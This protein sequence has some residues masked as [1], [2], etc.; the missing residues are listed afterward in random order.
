[1][2]KNSVVKKFE[3]LASKYGF[4]QNNLLDMYDID[5]ETN[6][7]E[8]TLF[9]IDDVHLERRTKRDFETE[10]GDL[11][12][13]G[14]VVVKCAY[15]MRWCLACFD[16][17]EAVLAG[18]HAIHDE[19]LRKSCL[20]YEAYWHFNSDFLLRSVMNEM[21]ETCILDTQ[22]FRRAH[23]FRHPDLDNASYQQIFKV[24]SEIVMLHFQYNGRLL[25]TN[26]A[27]LKISLLATKT[28]SHGWQLPCQG[29]SLKLVNQKEV[30]VIQGSTFSIVLCYDQASLLLGETAQ[31]TDGEITVIHQ[32]QVIYSGEHSFAIDLDDNNAYTAMVDRWYSGGSRWVSEVL[33][34][35]TTQRSIV[36][37]AE[38]IETLVFEACSNLLDIGMNNDLGNKLKIHERLY[39]RELSWHNFNAYLF[40]HL[41][42]EFLTID[43]CMQAVAKNNSC[44]EFLPSH[45]REN[46]DVGLAALKGAYFGGIEGSVWGQLFS[47][48]EIPLEA[49]AK[50]YIQEDGTDGYI[51][52]P[53]RLKT[54]NMLKYTVEKHPDCLNYTS[55]PSVFANRDEFEAFLERQIPGLAKQVQR[56]MDISDFTPRQAYEDALATM[57]LDEASEPLP[58]FDFS[59]CVIPA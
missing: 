49:L 8:K 34:Q 51:S 22:F 3:A 42:P 54:A 37:H 26:K 40:R 53:C 1:M 50:A 36:A 17:A 18:R 47:H 55:N 2:N 23:T 44:I 10:E 31:I 48:T 46:L 14:T 45:A 11:T 43:L 52:L 27:G 33:L 6:I 7:I 41:L 4:D 9:L 20:A 15:L 29:R 21:L 32:G 58:A 13:Y 28:Q 30:Q 5:D 12:A 57:A 56:I 39:L 38:E 16:S 35:K 24:V 19:R 59:D 25:K